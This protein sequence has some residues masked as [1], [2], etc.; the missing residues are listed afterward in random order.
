MRYI[1]IVPHKW[2]SVKLQISFFRQAEVAIDCSILNEISLEFLLRANEHVFCV[3]KHAALHFCKILYYSW[4]ITSWQLR[5]RINNLK[6]LKLPNCK[7]LITLLKI[8][9]SFIFMYMKPNTGG[10]LYTTCNFTL[11][12]FSNCCHT[13]ISIELVTLR[14]N[15]PHKLLS[16]KSNVT[17][18]FQIKRQLGEIGVLLQFHIF[19]K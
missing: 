15:H 18:W 2:L 5:S 14:N 6:K 9:A 7:I 8:I 19:V 17:L 4:E 11:V 16:I 10:E 3:R 12:I 13:Y 1:F